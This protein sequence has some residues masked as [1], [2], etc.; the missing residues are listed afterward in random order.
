MFSGE[1]KLLHSGF[2]NKQYCPVCS[3]KHPGEVNQVPNSGPSLM[4]RGIVSKKEVI[5]PYFFW[6]ENMTGETQKRFLRYYTFPKFVESSEDP[7][8]Q[9]RWCSLAHI[10]SCTSVFGPNVS[11]LGNEESWPQLMA[12]S[13][14][15]LDALWLLF[16]E[17][18]EWCCVLQAS[19]D[20]VRAEG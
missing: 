11:Q 8:F 14:T 9:T 18:L 20:N 16:M 5:G 13:L 15:R 10:L 7:I 4:V 1:C 19:Q 12:S 2:V 17:I 3:L 6:N